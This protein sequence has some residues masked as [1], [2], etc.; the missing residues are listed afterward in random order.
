M[1]EGLSVALPLR[2]DPIDGA[3]GLNK[4]IEA[5]ARQNLKM[6]ILTSPG[7]RT[8]IP[9]FGVGIRNYLFAQNAP[10]TVDLIR[11]RI[12]EQVSRYLPYIEL[13]ELRVFSPDVTAG[14]PGEIDNT[15]LIVVIS[16]S[17]PNAGIVSDLTIPVE[18]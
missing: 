6:V 14:L 7:E 8:M 3:Y 17:I 1:A 5:M 16:Y 2:F 10:G 9:E 4:N 12:Q 15:R 18:I 11:R 13:N